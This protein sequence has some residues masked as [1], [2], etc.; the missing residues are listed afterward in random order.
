MKD[1]IF[2]KNYKLQLYKT[3]SMCQYHFLHLIFIVIPVIYLYSVWK[4]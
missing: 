2:Q 3:M 1:Y 4:F